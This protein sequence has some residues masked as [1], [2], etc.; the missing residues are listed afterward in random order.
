MALAGVYEAAWFHC[1]SQLA[2]PKSAPRFAPG[3]VRGGGLSVR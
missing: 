2:C 3:R 1:I